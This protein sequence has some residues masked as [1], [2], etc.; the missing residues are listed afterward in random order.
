[1]GGKRTGTRQR[2]HVCFAGL[3]LAA[4]L[5]SCAQFRTA[6]C[7]VCERSVLPS[8]LAQIDRGEFDAAA[9]RG[10][11]MI[12]GRDPHADEALY[13]L[14]LVYAHAGNPKKDYRRSRECFARL[15]KDYP[16]SSLAGEAKIW[17]GLLDAME[18][19]K[20]IDLEIESRKKEV[21]K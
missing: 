19:T 16:A 3:I 8:L 20:Q 4:S 15:A 5:S 6:L 9:K 11:D 1:M 18:K 14:G 2:L 21:V 7:G 13:A 17:A 10:G 12:A